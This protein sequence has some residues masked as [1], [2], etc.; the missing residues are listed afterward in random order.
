MAPSISARR[1]APLLAL[2]AENGPAYRALAESLRRLIADGQVPVGTK[3]PSERDLGPV[4]GLSRTTVT[5]AYGLLRDSGYLVSKHGSGTRAVLPVT[6]GRRHRRALAPTSGAAVDGDIDLTAAAMPALP[7][8]AAAYEN[9]A[10]EVARY[11][12]GYGY[13]PLGLPELRAAVAEQYCARGL[14]TDA[15]QIMITPGALTGLAVAA[16][17]FLVAGDRVLVENPTYPNA[18]AAIGGVNARPVA[19]P[20]GAGG[21]DAD[22]AAATIAQTAPR[23]AYL[24]PDFHNPT[25]ALMCED[26]REQMGAALSRARTLCLVDETMVATGHDPAAQM[27][28]PFAVHAPHT[29]TLGSAGKSHWG[30]LR[31]GWIRAPK[32][33]LPALERARLTLDLGSPVLEQLVLARLLADEDALRDVRATYLRGH[34]AHLVQAL[35]ATVPQWRVRAADGGLA[36]WVQLPEPVSTAVS[37]A[38]EQHGVI[39]APGP[40]FSVDG[41]LERFLRIPFVRPVTE[42]TDAVHRLGLAAQQVAARPARTSSAGAAGFVA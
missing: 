27:P 9:A 37:T 12:G 5:R 40:Q 17:A 23:A 34:R 36:A 2:A 31:I 19:V 41:T 33:L 22:A 15:E 13:H 18:L 21:W 10:R 20:I 16:R 30:G 38:A 32:P 1:L 42:L 6:A 14:P 3:V 7:G 8:T 28:S 29:I 11:L 39:L 24:I 26:T 4:L 35:T 25:G